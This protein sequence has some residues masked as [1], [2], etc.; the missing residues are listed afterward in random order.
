MSTDV[1]PVVQFA[2]PVTGEVLT[3]ASPDA[4][5]AQYMADIRELESQIREHKALINRELLARLDKRRNW[6]LHLEG[7][8]K[9]SAPSDEPGEEWD[10]AGLHE[11]LCRLTDEELITE[12][13][14][15]AA[16]EIVTEYKVK[17]AGVNALRKNAR[18]AEV[19]NRFCEPAEK[20]RYV[21]VG[22]S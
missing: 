20:R 1:E 22:R 16:V 2:S 3:L 7:G 6:T 15:D 14:V 12:E 8:L 4:D 9:L 17:K 11:A 13:A 19:V 10:G 5:L 18:L 21:S